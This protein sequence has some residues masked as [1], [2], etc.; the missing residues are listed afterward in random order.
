[1]PK[2]PKAE[3][4]TPKDCI[5]CYHPTINSR[6]YCQRC[7]THVQSRKVDKLKR[8]RALIDAIDRSRDVFLCR[9]SK[10]VLELIDRSS[11]FWIQFD[12]IIPIETSA[13]QCLCAVFNAMKSQTSDEEFRQLIIMLKKHWLGAPF[14]RNA[15]KFEYFN[16]KKPKLAL[17]PIEDLRAGESPTKN[18][19]ICDDP[20]YTKSVYCARCRQYFRAN[21]ENLPRRAALKAAW[22]PVRRKFICFYTGAE[23]E[24]WDLYSPWYVSFDHGTPGISG[25]LVVA[26]MWISLM[27]VDLARYEFYPVVNELAECFET[28]KVFDKGVCEFKYWIRK[29]DGTRKLKLLPLV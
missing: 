14:D 15:V 11:P 12:H 6:V 16:R 25:D 13:F 18:C 22:D 7:R 19:I 10:L 23:L 2:P 21:R 4:P 1:M 24:E 17:G 20:S 26:A 8:R 9:Y 5:I 29:P 28:G 27:K 3:P